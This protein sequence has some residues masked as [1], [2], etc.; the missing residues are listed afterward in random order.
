MYGLLP[1]V[2]FAFSG[3]HNNFLSVLYKWFKTAK[4]TKLNISSITDQLS[5]RAAIYWTRGGGGGLG[6]IFAGYVLLASQSPYRIIVYSVVNSIWIL[7][8]Y[9]WL[10]DKYVIFAIPT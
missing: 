5:L 3:D 8:L 9:Y 7:T 2:N 1:V 4:A 6:L 10:L